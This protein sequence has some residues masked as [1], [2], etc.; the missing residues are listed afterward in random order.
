MSQQL[1]NAKVNTTQ[2]LGWPVNLKHTP[3]R[4]AHDILQSNYA[5]KY[6][7]IGVIGVPGSG[8]TTFVDCLIHHLHTKDPT[9]HVHKFK[10]DD[11]LR[12][13]KILTYELPKKQ[14][15]ILV[16]D[17][18]SYLFEQI[19][20]KKQSEILHQLTIVRE[21]LDDTKET[22]CIAILLYHYTYALQK[23]MR[24]AS[25]HIYTSINHEERENMKKVFGYDNKRNIQDFFRK[26][27]AMMR[28]RSIKLK[29]L[30]T[31]EIISYKRDEPFRLALVSNLGELHYCLYHRI[32]CIKCLGEKAK[33]DLNLR[34][35]TVMPDE[36]CTLVRRYGYSAVHTTVD[37]QAWETY[38]KGAL[39]H[40]KK[41][42]SNSLYNLAESNY[43][44]LPRI[45]Q[46]MGELNVNTADKEACAQALKAV[47]D[48]EELK[49]QKIPDPAEQAPDKEL[50]E[51][52]NETVLPDDDEDDDED[53]GYVEV[54][55][56][57]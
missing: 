5:T 55:T 41:V 24:Q 17:D 44:D 28:W 14:N 40:N 13:D 57:G 12:L 49:L 32:A 52:E 26:F 42:I 4:L 11:L 37:H 2:I 34:A 46:V 47:L 18:V 10:K 50:V 3:A 7:Q 19:P 45:S 38:R 1:A 16:F 43:L 53:D 20:E 15:C 9:L 25:F 8:K 22:R 6:T 31:G 21:K 27:I 36:I 35:K 29:N 30:R 56:D 54:K 23:G 33:L 51:L 39:H 48:M